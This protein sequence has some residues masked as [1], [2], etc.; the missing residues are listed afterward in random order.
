MSLDPTSRLQHRINNHGNHEYSKEQADHPWR[1]ASCKYLHDP[2]HFETRPG[3]CYLCDGPL[4]DDK[5]EV[6]F[7][8]EASDLTVPCSTVW[9]NCSEDYVHSVCM[10]KYMVEQWPRKFRCPIC[11]TVDH[12]WANE[13]GFLAIV[14][15]VFMEQMYEKASQLMEDELARFIMRPDFNMVAF[16]ARSYTLNETKSSEGKANEAS[17]VNEQANHGEG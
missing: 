14:A 13:S 8:G 3:I 1:R 4:P 5:S 17:Q 16:N 9:M 12:C 6:H 11:R 7:D 15:S 2:K 10:A